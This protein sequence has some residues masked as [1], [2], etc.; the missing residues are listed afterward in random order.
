MPFVDM[1][2]WKQQEIIDHASLEDEL[3]LGSATYW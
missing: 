3:L 1:H 2:Q